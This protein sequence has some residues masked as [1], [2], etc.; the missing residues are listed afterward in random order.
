MLVGVAA[1]AVWLAVSHAADT[2][3][4]GL[5]AHWSFDE[6]QGITAADASP[7]G[8]NVTVDAKQWTEGISGTALGSGERFEPVAV[9]YRKCFD[10]A[11][12]FTI[13]AWVR[14]TEGTAFIFRKRGGN[15]AERHIELWIATRGRACMLT[16]TPVGHKTDNASLS[17][18]LYEHELSDGVWHHVAGVYDAR[19]GAQTVYIDG[20]RAAR[21]ASIHPVKHIEKAKQIL[22][23]STTLDGAIDE[24]RVYSRPLRD[25]EIA[26]S[27]RKFAPRQV[28]HRDRLL[29]AEVKRERLSWFHSGLFRCASLTRPPIEALRG[30][31]KRF[32]LIARAMP[33]NHYGYERT[34]QNL[35]QLR[36]V[37]VTDIIQLMIRGSLVFH[38]TRVPGAQ[39]VHY[40][41]RKPFQQGDY[42]PLMT[43]VKAAS[44]EGIDVW[45]KLQ[46][47]S[48]A[49]EEH[50]ARDRQGAPY[51]RKTGGGKTRVVDYLSPKYRAFLHGMIDEYAGRYNRYGS[52]RGFNVDMPWG[53]THDFFGDDIPAFG[54]YCKEHFKEELPAGI[55]EKIDLGVQWC[56]PKS[57]WWRRFVLFKQWVG[58]D[59][60]SDLAAHSKKRGLEYFLQLGSS[61]GGSNGWAQAHDAFRLSRLSKWVWAYADSR[62]EPV[63]VLPHSAAGISSYGHWARF[64]TMSFRGH[65]IGLQY[66]Y[67]VLYW[68]FGSGN[69]ARIAHEF[70]KH[71]RNIFEWAGAKSLTRVA[72]L[73]NQTG[74][75]LRLG[76][77]AREEDGLEQQ[78]IEVMSRSYD[79]DPLYV[80]HT[81]AY[82]RYTTLVAP[83]NA[84]NGVS[85][86][87]M[88]GL[89]SYVE[90]GGIVVCLNAKW[91]TSRPDLTDMRDVTEELTGAPFHEPE[92]ED[93]ELVLS[94]K[95]M[96]RGKVV[97]VTSPDV[98][99]VASKGE[100][101]LLEDLTQRVGEYASPEIRVEDTRGE[102][103]IRVVTSLQKNNWIGIS[104]DANGVAPDDALLR[105]DLKRLGLAGRKGYRIFLLQKELEYFGPEHKIG[106]DYAIQGKLPPGQPNWWTEQNLADGV[107][108]PIFADLRR[109][110]TLPEDLELSDVAGLKDLKI[111]PS[112]IERLRGSQAASWHKTK[113]DRF[114]YEIVVIAPCD[115][116]TIEGERI[117]R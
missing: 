50:C 18:R 40:L 16:G 84:L 68:P 106:G 81:A 73:R 95:P 6:G 63:L 62:N 114:Q 83:R 26:A 42:D 13:E 71:I 116:L 46:V 79:V 113:R 25:E 38:P 102:R 52:M 97:A 2:R 70:G 9:P 66:F 11:G 36:R 103:N 75:M 39:A 56:E 34:R 91:A 4:Q 28:Q 14:K 5:V 61:P 92:G 105:V 64:N 60:L 88:Q 53:H 69:T 93:G 24:L 7:L 78:L 99:T 43:L 31:G 45:I 47:T 112:N 67:R 90:S 82:P 80:E 107:R 74:I 17:S 19:A 55:E 101:R 15:W 111:S 30:P 104:L 3:G 51:S 41:D 110:L 23:G 22:I 65:G 85:Q 59:F 76:K 94:V 58:D 29:L 86:E 37:G 57:R 10:M 49:S 35:R 27:Y 33:L 54:A 72:V 8:N 20:A 117:G 98:M 108:I 87:T 1:A 109:E 115:E 100:S 44:E 89:R 48:S 21:R 77:N 32:F 96:G 12:G